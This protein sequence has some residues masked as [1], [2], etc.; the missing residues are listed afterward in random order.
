MY[1][2]VYLF[3]FKEMVDVN[4]LS[5]VNSNKAINYFQ[6]IWLRFN[7]MIEF[8]ERHASIMTYKTMVEFMMCEKY[9][10]T[11]GF[12]FFNG[13]DYIN[14]SNNCN[15]W[16]INLFD[17]IYH[18]LSDRLK[19]KLIKIIEINMYKNINVSSDIVVSFI[20][21]PIFFDKYILHCRN[22]STVVLETSTLLG[23]LISPLEGNV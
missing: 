19:E 9:I 7:D 14:L 5:M 13:L 6:K 18:K 1:D 22:Y 16:I 21:H 20:T 10:V 8:R 15:I 17:Y 4:I 11:Y 3:G 12:T 23:K 2:I